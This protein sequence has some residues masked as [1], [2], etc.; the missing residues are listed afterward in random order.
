MTSPEAPRTIGV[1]ETKAPCFSQADA[2]GAVREVF[3][4]EAEARALYSERDQNFHVRAEDGREFVLKVSNPAEDPAVV[5]FHTQALLHIAAVDASLPVPRV[6]PAADGVPYRWVVGPDGRRSLVR[7]LTFLPG[8]LLDHMRPSP[9]LLREIGAVTARLARALRGFFHP[10]ARHE[11]LW[12][13]L[14]V[15]H[16]REHTRHIQD[17]ELRRLIE[18]TLADFEERVLPQLRGLRAQV[19][20]N[21]MSCH[22][23]LVDPIGVDR[24]TGVIDFGDMIH[25]PLVNDIAVPLAEMLSDQS[26]R[27]EAAMQ[28]V[29]GYHSV[30]RFTEDEIRVAFD[31]ATVRAAMGLTVAAWREKDHPENIDYITEGNAGYT[32][33]L[34][35]LAAL[36]RGF[37]QACLRD[38]CGLPAA[39][40]ALAVNCWLQERGA[41]AAPLF[42]L[43]LAAARKRV[44]AAGET[45][46]APIGALDADG[47]LAIAAHACEIGCGGRNAPRSRWSD[48]EVCTLHLG[49]DLYAPAD[50]PVASPLD[51][52]VHAVV[53]DPD[54]S[55]GVA[56]ILEHAPEAGVRFYGVFRPLRP[57]DLRLGK[58]I[59]RGERIGAIAEGALPHLHFQLATA[60]PDTDA[61]PPSCCEPSK[62]RVWRSFCPDPNALLGIPREAFETRDESQEQLL[63]RRAALLGS[64]L[65]IFYDRPV[66]AVRATGA[67][68]IDASGRAYIDAYNNVP[69]V[70]HCHPAVLETLTR[71]AATLNTNTRYLFTS[72]LDYAARLTDTLPEGLSMCTFVNSGSEAN[73]LAW[74]IA[75]AYTGHDGAIVLRDA[76]HGITDAVFD[77]SPKMRDDADIAPHVAT[78]PAPDD[79]RGPHRRGEPDLGERYA[80][81]VDEAIGV[82]RRR[83]H[84]LAALYIDPG[85]MSSGILE[86][87]EGYLP[88]LFA[89]VRA[90]GGLCV[91]DEV[92]S[93]FGRM[94]THLWGFDA[95]GGVPDIVTLGK[96]IG[97]GHPL[98]ALVTRPE[99]LR[100][101][102]QRTDVFSTFGGNTVACAVGLTVLDVLEREGLRENALRVGAHLKA[103][104]QKLAARHPLIGD[105]RGSGLIVGVELVR[106][107]ESLEPA[108]QEAHAVMNRMREDG[109]LIG[110]SGMHGNVLKVRP[111]LAFSESDAQRLA[112]ALDRALGSLA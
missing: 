66:H 18:H 49:V 104:L 17:R 88:T 35:W 47:E 58:S 41:T 12:D 96:P 72:V 68:L 34:E 20:H 97:N 85:L 107:R 81:Y 103:R 87:P 62:Q 39:S 6:V 23:T 63:E 75:K 37:A 48:A 74:R 84:E 53:D 61:L 101:L 94:G 38:A 111:P 14:Q 28:I 16:L 19:I 106:D 102:T 77:F 86:A 112:D 40:N 52:T 33:A 57:V 65:E 2:E 83:G 30:E 51:A 1:L 82:L 31:L 8:Q 5:D 91:A 36:D 15:P 9:E 105:V 24:V 95:L 50:T 98:A 99:I 3:R 46:T 64:E 100:S 11:L 59:A 56:V 27:L 26:D 13:L 70:G 80:A 110:L 32:E 93:G 90:A 73:D 29:A 109:V 7:L 92:Q 108:A 43:D 10:A 42:D 22:N 45:P 4:L 54:A 89:R 60:L 55:D 25:A 71:Q 78:I 79:Y 44:L 67:R 69:Q 21:D 76:Y